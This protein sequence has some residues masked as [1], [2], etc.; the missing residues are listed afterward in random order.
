MVSDVAGELPTSHRET[1]EGYI[2]EVEGVEQLRQICGESV[3]VV[4]TPRL[5][6]LTETAAVIRDHA[7][8]SLDERRNLT[9][10]RTATEWPP[11]NQNDRLTGAV[12]VEVQFDRVLVFGSNSDERHNAPRSRSGLECFADS[13]RLQPER[14][15]RARREATPQARRERQ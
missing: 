7:V 11:M 13:Q 6:R 8:A 12:V 4:A 5:R 14:R 10:P 2:G 3:V 9:L 15:R 1:D